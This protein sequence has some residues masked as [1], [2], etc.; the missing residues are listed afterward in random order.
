ML[1]DSTI[2]RFLGV[3]GTGHNVDDSGHFSIRYFSIYSNSMVIRLHSSHGGLL[4][5]GF[6]DSRQVQNSS[7]DTK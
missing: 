3:G 5:G 1:I 2:L 7:D 6:L 4:N